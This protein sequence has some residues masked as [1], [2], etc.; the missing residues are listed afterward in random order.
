MGIPYLEDALKEKGLLPENHYASDGIEPAEEI[1]NLDES[2]DE[3]ENNEALEEIMNN[4]E[5]GFAMI[6]GKDHAEGMDVVYKET[7]RHARDLMDYGYNC[8]DKFRRG[9]FEQAN[10][11]YGRAVEAKNSK[12]D[13]QLKAMKLA[14]D[15]RKLALEEKKLNALLGKAA[16]N[17]TI[18]NEGYIVEDRNAIIKSRLEQ[19]KKK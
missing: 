17:G 15:Q 9:I 11:F 3:E 2:F 10:N 4:A 1:E 14:L 6:E 18:T 13:S 5:K 8:E 19:M 12:R 16:E 7:L